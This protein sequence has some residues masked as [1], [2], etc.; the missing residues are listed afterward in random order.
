MYP[1]KFKNQEHAAN[2][3]KQTKQTI[4]YK[5]KRLSE[6]IQSFGSTEG[7]DRKL[8][9]AI[10]HTGRRRQY[11]EARLDAAQRF[12]EGRPSREA[13]KAERRREECEKWDAED[14]AKM[15]NSGR[16]TVE[17]VD[18]YFEQRDAPA[19]FIDDIDYR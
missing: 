14:R 13:E 10:A 6:Y 17:E 1:I 11:L 19:N 4:E 9:T 12:V 5:L 8:A 7:C 3:I 15:L 16:W 18:A 2:E